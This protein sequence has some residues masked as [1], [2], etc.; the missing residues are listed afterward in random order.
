LSAKYGIE[1]GI[2]IERS[3]KTLEGN[4]F[5]VHLIT[6]NLQ[7][8]EGVSVPFTAVKVI[9][10]HKLSRKLFVGFIMSATG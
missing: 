2:S 10:R 8:S 3:K 1:Y 5:V 4:Y 9:C 7:S 6:E